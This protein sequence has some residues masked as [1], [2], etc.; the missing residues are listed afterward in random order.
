MLSDQ[1]D[2]LVIDVAVANA[3][4]KGVDA[5][6]QHAFR[7]LER[8][9]MRGDAQPVLVRLIDNRNV[10]CWRQ[11]LILAVPVVDPNLDDIST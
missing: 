4:S 7:V 5:R 8:E 6:A 2:E 9:D 10:Q 1:G 11:L 3:M